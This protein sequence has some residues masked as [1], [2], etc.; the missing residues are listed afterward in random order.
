MMAA[1]IFKMKGAAH[2]KLVQAKSQQSE[3]LRAGIWDASSF[4]R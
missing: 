2:L 3:W 1:C 4:K